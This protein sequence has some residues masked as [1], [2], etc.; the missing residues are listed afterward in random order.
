MKLPHAARAIV[1]ERK[2]THYL[3]NPAHPT[4]RSKARFFQHFGYMADKWQILAENLMRHAR[5]N[6]VV[7]MEP[8]RYGTRYVVD[9]FL[10]APDG[11]CL[12]IRTAWFID[13]GTD[14][15]RFVTAH[16]LPKS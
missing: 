5:E 7:A 11:T 3:L 14:Q 2:I 15:P 1:P 13:L 4:G 16:P 6:E 10:T 12:K 9:G 8:G